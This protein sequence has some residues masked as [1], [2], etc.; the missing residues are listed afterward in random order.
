MSEQE[1]ER[2]TAEVSVFTAVGLR[3]IEAGRRYFKEHPDERP[4]APDVLD[5]IEAGCRYLRER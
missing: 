5:L 4:A 2:P 3:L 1:Q